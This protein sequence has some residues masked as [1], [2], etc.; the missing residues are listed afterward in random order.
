MTAMTAQRSPAAETPA[1]SRAATMRAVTQDRYG[2]PDVLM[3]RDVPRPEIG[4]DG[5]LVR[6]RAVSLNAADWHLMRGEPFIARLGEGLRTPKQTTPGVDVA[7]VVEAIGAG[8]TELAVGDEVF[9][10]RSG[11]LAEL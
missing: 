4:D 3:L 11:S 9:G 10:A 5:V 7:G 1:I 6:V 8:V 2:S